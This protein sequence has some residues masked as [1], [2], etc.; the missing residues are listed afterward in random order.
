MDRTKYLVAVNAC[1]PDGDNQLSP[2]INT[3][4]RDFDFTL[5]FQDTF[6]Q[7]I[8]SALFLLVALIRVYTLRGE[9]VKVKS[10]YLAKLKLALYMAL[11][12]TFGGFIISRLQ[13]D[14]LR[15]SM[16]A[17]SGIFSL[18]AISA[19]AGLSYLEDQ[20]SI[21]PSD[22]LVPYFSLSAIFC[23]LTLRS[24]WLIP[25]AVTPRVLWTL[26][27]TITTTIVYCESFTKS[28]LTQ[29][30]EH[31]ES[32]EQAAGFW[33]RSFLTWLIPFLRLGYSNTI[34]LAKIPRVDKY[35]REA[36][37]RVRLNRRWQML[38]QGQ[39]CLVRELFMSNLGLFLSAIPARICLSAFIVSQPLLIEASIAHLSNVDNGQKNTIP[40]Y[41][42]VIVYILVYFGITVSRTLYWRQTYRLVATFRSALVSLLY[43]H[44]TG[45]RVSE[46][47]ET[48]AVTLMGTD[49]E[50]IVE[51]VKN[52]H[53]IWAAI[54]E[55]VIGV[56]LIARQM[57][58]AF[59]APLAICLGA[60][61]T[62]LK[63]SAAFKTAQGSWNEKVQARVST[64]AEVLKNIKAVQML[65]LSRC[66]NDLITNLRKV[67]LQTSKHF[68]KLIVCQ[69]F[70]G[71]APIMIAP[72]ATFALYAVKGFIT[73]DKTLLSTQAFACLSL[74]T[75][76]TDP[77]VAFCEFWPGLFQALAS[78]DRIEK[79]CLRMRHPGLPNNTVSA[80]EPTEFRHI[81]LQILPSKTTPT[82][83]LMTFKQANVAWSI[84]SENV[85]WNLTLD[86]PR[87][88]TGITGPV[89]SGKSTLLW[90]MVGETSVNTG[91]VSGILT[92]S[93][94]CGQPPWIMDES[95][96][97]NIT[98]GLEYDQ[99][100]FDF[101][102][103][104]VCLQDDIAN[105][106]RG[107]QTIA[108]TNGAAL[109]GGQQQRLALAR[110]IYSRL[111]VVVLDDVLSGLDASTSTRIWAR[112]FGRNGYFRKADIS[113]ILATSD[114]KLL[115]TMDTI[116]SLDGGHLVQ[117]TAP[118]EDHR[119]LSNS[120]LHTKTDIRELDA[121]VM[122]ANGAS[123]IEDGSF[124][125]ESETEALIAV[126]DD[127]YQD[128]WPVYVYY[129]RSAGITSLCGW[130]IC[131]LC[132]ATFSSV[133]TIWVQKWTE[134]RQN[135]NGST[136][137]FLG[138]YA[139][140]MVLTNLSMIGEMWLAF[141]KIINDTALTL[142][143]DLLDTTLR[144]PY[145][146]FQSVDMG[147][148]TNRF[149]QDMDLI[150]MTLPSHAVVFT[151]AASACMVQLVII[152]IV[153]KYLVI[154]VPFF[155][156]GAFFLQ[157]FY[158][159]TSRQ[160]RLIDIEAKAPLYNHFLELI[161]G[162]PTIRAYGRI[163]FFCKKH[164]DALDAS[165]GPFYIVLCIQQWLS[166]ML[167]LMVGFLT[168]VV[169]TIAIMSPGTM[170]PGEL[171]AALVLLLQFNNMAMQS[172]RGWTSLEMS[173]SAVARV[174]DFLKR[175]PVEPTGWNNPRRPWPTSG[176][177]CWKGVVAGYSEH[178]VPI[179]KNIN[180]DIAPGEKLAIC[181]PSGSGKTS[182]ILTLLRMTKQLG[183]LI[184]VDDVDI[185]TLS[186]AALRSCLNVLPQHPFFI[187]GTVEL[188]L[189]PD[190]QFSESSII[191][192]LTKVK[193][194]SKVTALGGLKAGLDPDK[195][196]QGQ[197]QL[198][199]LARALLKPSKIVILDEATSSV[200]DETEST[201]LDIIDE[202]FKGCTVISVVHRLARIDWYDRVAVLD[203]G[204]I[205]E[206]DAPW[207][208]LEQD[209]ALRV[210][211]R[212][213]HTKKASVG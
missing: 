115:H 48:A 2:R 166:M 94:F 186:T 42:L 203:Q 208:L 31:G 141:M 49:V 190:G 212:D 146:F 86:I 137:Y 167:D 196:S 176:G 62:I 96:R 35:L 164:S 128:N 97:H 83:I 77:L 131:S 65:G 202:E 88:F 168:V 107:D 201:M 12:I 17:I 142:H 38:D 74:I 105:L 175:T 162:A 20:R 157:R 60:V 123:D 163:G 85:L 71:N 197:K 184:I 67:E 204:R 180:I 152:C 117:Q 198:L 51:S 159:R 111:P 70:F 134:A 11:L 69:I 179:L 8:P 161:S 22:V 182:M 80:I 121:G 91:Y 24:L 95:I 124:Q 110:A 153:G 23:V 43:H 9:R 136:I 68:R 15:T 130:A 126:T 192:A 172:I 1:P 44:T 209:S 6:F 64:T 73:N 61:V 92:R 104:C 149:S 140:L 160:V 120:I 99:E 93:A 113:V 183:G 76:L 181:G 25:S 98:M 63:M 205:V 156:V 34:T 207:L 81:P 127:P 106:P 116:I 53:E 29:P 54:P 170:T 19:S 138:V 143:T 211:Y 46:T 32:T 114:Q 147:V 155:L 118:L 90:S 210:M 39:K 100:W 52:I 41:A 75:I 16:S 7:T 10:W 112:L 87:G 82:N 45:V 50:Q 37:V 125:T 21:R 195:W 135:S 59:I 4:C 199:C 55:I 191:A 5:L 40:A 3:N 28:D 57:S 78:F 206:C 148:I 174:Q 177:I 133:S 173:I 171:G 101:S 122:D 194:M 27:L 13:A 89:A 103:F 213:Y 102:I 151:T 165:Q 187:P 154:A 178:A 158:L 56:W 26:I 108:G 58:W 30:P 169:V 84:D 144:A 47:R 79:Y 129:G 200:D 188:N 66:V 139:L 72:F 150:D 189:D 36:Y 18:M 185:S 109:S 145:N 14:H 33:S 132:A 119:H 193:L